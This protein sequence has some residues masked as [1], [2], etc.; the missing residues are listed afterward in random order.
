MGGVFYLVHQNAPAA[1]VTLAFD[2]RKPGGT[3]GA[4]ALVTRWPDS[5]STDLT[6]I[7][8]DA[9]RDRMLV[10]SEASDRLLSF[11]TNGTPA[12]E[13]HLP[14]VQQEGICLDGEGRVWVADDR[15]G[16]LLR[17]DRLPAF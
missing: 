6:A 1:V 14:G 4:T 3:L 7:T 16:T 11:R 13:L 10:I 15:A 17:S 9:P 2:P 12:G 5:R 8:Y